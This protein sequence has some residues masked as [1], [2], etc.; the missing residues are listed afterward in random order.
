MKEAALKEAALKEAAL[1]EVAWGPLPGCGDCQNKHRF[2]V[3]PGSRPKIGTL[4]KF[5]G[6]V[7]FKSLPTFRPAWLAGLKSEDS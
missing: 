7:D 6:A 5:G 1:K 3:L 2:G 4:L